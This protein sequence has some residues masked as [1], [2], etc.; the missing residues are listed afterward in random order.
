MEYIQKVIY[1]KN[2]R[3]QRIYGEAFIPNSQGKFPL[4]IFSHGYGYNFSFIDSKRLASKGISIY[5]FDFYGRSNHSRSEG[6]TTEMSVMTEAD[7]LESVLEQMK[8]QNFVDKNNIYLCGASQGGLVSIIVGE[9]R[10]NDLKGLILYCAGLAILDYYEPYMR[11]KKSFEEFRLLNMTIRRKY[12]DDIINFDV[13]KCIQN[14][15]IPFLYY[16]GDDDECVN[17]KYAY[18]AQKY[19]NDKGKLIILK[20][21]PHM[22]C[23]GNENRLFLDILNFIFNNK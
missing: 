23:Y 22:L 18:K 4:I 15:Q 14:I 3:N 5:Q 9:R 12:F 13:Y 2:K 1:C 6:K 10:Q 8:L 17:V 21:A 11:N 20:N 16:H 19:F 7:D